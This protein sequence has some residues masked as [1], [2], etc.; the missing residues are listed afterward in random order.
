MHEINGVKDLQINILNGNVYNITEEHNVLCPMYGTKYP[1]WIIN[2]EALIL[3]D[4]TYEAPFNGQIMY[5]QLNFRYTN[6]HFE[7]RFRM[8]IFDYTPE[9]KWQKPN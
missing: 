9:L 6:K 1:T 7:H 4:I 5:H 3:V 8:L 2:F